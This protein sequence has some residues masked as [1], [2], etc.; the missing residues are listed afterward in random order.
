[1][2]DEVQLM[3]RC[4]DL[5]LKGMGTVTP[6]PM[7]GALLIRDGVI[8]GEGFHSKSGGPHAEV[9]AISHAESLGH[10]VEGATIYCSLEPCCHTNKKTPPCT[11][12]ILQK[13]ISKVIISNLDPNPYVAGKGVERL[14]QQG[15]EVEVGLLKEEGEELNR[16]FFHTIKTGLPYLH[17]KMA[18]TLDGRIASETNDSKWITDEEARTRVHQWRYE[19]DAVMVGR[20]TFIADNPGLDIRHI[21]GKGK[22]PFRVIVG[23]PTKLNWDYKLLADM[24]TDKTIILTTLNKWTECPPSLKDL[25]ASRHIRVVATD[26]LQEGLIALRKLGITSILAEGGAALASS[27][28]SQKL[29]Q[30]FSLFIAPKLMGNG[31]SSF[32]Q[33]DHF[34]MAKSLCFQRVAWTPMGNQILFEGEL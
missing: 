5:A 2:L 14:S 13:K 28:L 7:V 19:Y 23:D 22:I 33:N 1:M 27:L 21:D 16:V 17:L 4:F 11:E 30:R 24:H 25:I 9:V 10:S 34:E 31:P 12:L 18:Q 26:N 15:V 29:V 6:N 3:K 32:I 8:L 20:G